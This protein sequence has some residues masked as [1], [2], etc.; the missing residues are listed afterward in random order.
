MMKDTPPKQP[1]SPPDKHPRVQRKK[2][3]RIF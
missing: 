1:T 2:W 3:N